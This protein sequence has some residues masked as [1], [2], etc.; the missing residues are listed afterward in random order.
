MQT[1]GNL[2][3]LFVEFTT[4][5]KPGQNKLKGAYVFSRM[6]ADRNTTSVINN[7]ANVTFF[8][9]NSNS[10]AVAGHCFINTVINNLIYK[11]MKS[12][13][14]RRTDIHTRTFTNCF[15]SFQYLNCTC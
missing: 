4:G 2:V 6:H 7:T 1:A 5:M 15:Q 3:V 11:V 9:R 8:E 14:T 13:W 12:V 10:V